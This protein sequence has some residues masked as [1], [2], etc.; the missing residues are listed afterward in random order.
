M[1]VVSAS[2]LLSQTITKDIEE[3]PMPTS[4]TCKFLTKVMEQFFITGNQ[5]RT[6][7]H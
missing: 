7:V 3:I 4:Y 2:K 1:L 5:H 6:A